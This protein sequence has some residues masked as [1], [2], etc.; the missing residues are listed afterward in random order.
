MDD[1]EYVTTLLSILTNPTPTGIDPA[2]PYGQADDGI[3]RYNGFG[4][5]VWVTAV[6]I[7]DGPHG[8]ELRVSFALAVPDEPQ[9][10]GMQTRG[11]VQVPFDAEWRELS[12]FGDPAA[13]A[14]QVAVR[15]ESAAGELAQRHR[16]GDARDRMRDQVRARLPDRDGQRQMLLEMLRCEGTVTELGLGRFELHFDKVNEVNEVNEVDESPGGPSMMTVVVTPEEW[17]EVLVSGAGDDL[18]LYIAEVIADPDPDE[19]F[20]VFYDGDLTCSTREERPP[21]RGRARE[22]WWAELRASHP[23]GEN[24]GWF[25]YEPTDSEHGLGTGG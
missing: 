9:W 5:D 8:D 1:A 24:D 19:R 22:R 2:D 10:H 12:G 14:P 13:Y 4:T 6:E 20:L 7:T 16:E 23:P 25:A 17:E 15:V 3:D 18:C 21:V 11:S